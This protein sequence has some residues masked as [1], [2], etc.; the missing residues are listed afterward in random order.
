[1]VAGYLLVLF[2][3]V[4]SVVSGSFTY[5]LTLVAEFGCGVQVCWLV[6]VAFMR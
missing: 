3:L 5:C 2:G 4:V 1:M 6:G